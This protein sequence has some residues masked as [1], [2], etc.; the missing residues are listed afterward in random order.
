MMMNHYENESGEGP[1]TAEQMEEQ[2]PT[3]LGASLK[4]LPGADTSS[5]AN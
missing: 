2:M 3:S 4:Q 5:P 1:S